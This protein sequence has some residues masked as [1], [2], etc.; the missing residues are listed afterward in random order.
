MLLVLMIYARLLEMPP[1]KRTLSLLMPL[2]SVTHSK[3]IHNP[4]RVNRILLMIQKA[5]QHGTLTEA[6][7][8]ALAEA[9]QQ[10]SNSLNRE[11]LWLAYERRSPE[12]VR[13]NTE[14]RTDIISLVRFA[15]GESAFLEPFSVSVNRR[16]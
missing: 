2:E 11:S 5:H 12:N 16:F 7:L 6:N 4:F 9:L 8:K 13:G 10:H 1:P 3:P 14:Q 15:M